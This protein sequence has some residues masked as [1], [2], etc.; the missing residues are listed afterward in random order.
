MGDRR[1]CPPSQGAVDPSASLVAECSSADLV[2]VRPV[3]LAAGSDLAEEDQAAGHWASLALAA[4]GGAKR[5]AGD[6]EDAKVESNTVDLADLEA[7]EA[8]E[9]VSRRSSK[10]APPAAA[11]AEIVVDP[12]AYCRAL[13]RAHFSKTEPSPFQ[14]CSCS[15]E[16]RSGSSRLAVLQRGSISSSSLECR[17]AVSRVVQ[18]GSERGSIALQ[19]VSYTPLPLVPPQK[20]RAPP[21][22]RLLRS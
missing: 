18:N 4:V 15:A 7:A 3:L 9:L 16:R 22:P 2:A 10:R 8:A 19:V 12:A 21:C 1:S 5:Y 11:V 6:A 20:P 17:L 13:L 14:S